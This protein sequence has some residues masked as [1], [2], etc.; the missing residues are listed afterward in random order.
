MTR[1]IARMLDAAA[2]APFGVVTTRPAANGVTIVA[3]VPTTNLRPGSA[4]PSL[5]WFAAGATAWPVTA[6]VME[7][8]RFSSQTFIPCNE[9]D[10]LILVAPH[11][12]AG[13]PDLARAVAFVADGR[14]A[15]TFH[16]DT[17]H[18]PLT[19]FAAAAFAV[20]TCLA[21][22]ADDEEFRDLPEP[23]EVLA[24]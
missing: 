4:T 9:A 23:V 10:W 12:A 21:G 22:D 5:A 2:F 1:L 8:H 3:A 24:G 7:R 17:W 13:G 6:R 18:H 20:L 16:A 11:G 19:A 15:V 14:H